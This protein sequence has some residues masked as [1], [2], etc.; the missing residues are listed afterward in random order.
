MY[1]KRCRYVVGSTL[2]AVRCRQ[3]VVGSALEAIT[4]LII[5]V[6]S[7]VI[8]SIAVSNASSE[9]LF[10]L[11][12]VSAA[13]GPAAASSSSSRTGAGGAAASL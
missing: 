8:A 10:V 11:W 2:S 3:Y 6:T 13:A 9:L 1:L 7:D 5:S 12:D 4:S